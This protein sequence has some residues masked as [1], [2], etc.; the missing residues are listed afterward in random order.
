MSKELYR[1]VEHDGMEIRAHYVFGVKEA[2]QTLK[3]LV[4]QEATRQYILANTQTLVNE[5]E[6]EKEN[7]SY[8]V[9]RSPQD[10]D[11]IAELWAEPVICVRCH[12]KLNTNNIHSIQEVA[13]C[14]T[15]AFCVNCIDQEE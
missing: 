10:R 2:K 7:E 9:I 13:A 3:H 1:V 15:E 6:V 12:T 8:Y 14:I 4:E 11:Y 5:K